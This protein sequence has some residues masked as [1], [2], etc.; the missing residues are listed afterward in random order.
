MA[1]L[2]PILDQNPTV[3]VEQHHFDHIG[4]D[5]PEWGYSA[6]AKSQGE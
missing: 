5:D 3:S 1:K 6:N 2:P 4:K